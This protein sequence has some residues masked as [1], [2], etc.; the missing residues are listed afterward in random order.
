MVGTQEMELKA[1]KVFLMLHSYV[2]AC[3]GTTFMT[4]CLTIIIA[5]VDGGRSRCDFYFD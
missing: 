1:V 2:R 5:E 4:H 3:I